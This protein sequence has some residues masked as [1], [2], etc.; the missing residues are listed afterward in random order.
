[1]LT[2][3]HVP[4]RIRVGYELSYL[5]PQPTPVILALNVHYSRVS[6][7]VEPDHIV[8]NPGVPITAYRDLSGTGVVAS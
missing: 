3:A 8:I 4:M 6:D 5:F 7:L 1:M 2:F